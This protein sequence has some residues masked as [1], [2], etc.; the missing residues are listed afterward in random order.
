MT[1][2]PKNMF[3]ALPACTEGYL[4]SMQTAPKKARGTVPL[5][6]CWFMEVRDA[7]EE[8]KKWAANAEYFIISSAQPFKALPPHSQKLPT[9]TNTAR[10]TLT[11]KYIPSNVI[12]K[13]SKSAKP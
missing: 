1:M 10:N 13:N 4:Y 9:S 11:K 6:L 8:E 5:C 7:Q 12:L 3:W 2:P